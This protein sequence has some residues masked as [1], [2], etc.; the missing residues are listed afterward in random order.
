[1]PSFLEVQV[2]LLKPIEVDPYYEG[3]TVFT[4]AGVSDVFLLV[5]ITARPM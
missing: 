2:S 4:T 5:S 1:L 3:E